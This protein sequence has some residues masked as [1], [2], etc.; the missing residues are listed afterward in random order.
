[1]EPTGRAPRRTAGRPPKPEQK[2]DPKPTE[3]R[4]PA[5]PS[6]RKKGRVAPRAPRKTDQRPR[7]DGH[8]RKTIQ[9]A[10]NQNFATTAAVPGVN[11][12]RCTARDITSPR[13]ARRVLVRP[14][15]WPLL[16]GSG[17]TG[18]RRVRHVG[19]YPRQ[20]ERIKRVRVTADSLASGA[21]RAEGRGHA[22][23]VAREMRGRARSSGR[24]LRSPSGSSGEQLRQRARS[25]NKRAPMPRR[26][27]P[28]AFKLLRRATPQDPYGRRTGESM[29]QSVVCARC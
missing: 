11:V 2:P 15:R 27:R 25:S 5:Q 21:R 18:F 29:R 20:T 3:G 28:A 7:R 23:Q 8:R 16:D 1:M 17:L 13:A 19:T 6:T 10:P 14:A 9:S 26:S 12:D 22:S 24:R 4:A